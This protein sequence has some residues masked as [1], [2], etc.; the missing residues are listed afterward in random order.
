[1][2]RNELSLLAMEILGCVDPH[3]TESQEKKLKFSDITLRN[4]RPHVVCNGNIKKAIERVRQKCQFSLHDEKEKDKSQ[5]T[6]Y[7]KNK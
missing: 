1:M 7:Y 2:S 3:S 5:D 4:I 6:Q